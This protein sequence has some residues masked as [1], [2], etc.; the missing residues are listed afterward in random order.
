MN[1]IHL[2]APFTKEALVSLRAGE[3]VLVSGVVYTARDAAH[4]RL[5]AAL[6]A[7]EALPVDLR[8]QVVFYA[9]PTPT[10]PNKPCGAIGP[11]TSGRMD[12][13][14]PALLAYGVNAMIGKGE[15]SEAVRQA[16][17]A[18]GAVYFAAI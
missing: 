13:Y 17:M 11:T 10:P 9:G 3:R 5:C 12:A 15:R 6:Q 8:G 2:S 14:T 7:G 16:V 18:H 1:E 4:A